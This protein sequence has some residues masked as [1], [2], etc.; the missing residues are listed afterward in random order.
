[1]YRNAIVKVPASIWLW[2]WRVSGF[3]V[4]SS[5][6][7]Q[8]PGAEFCSQS[9]TYWIWFSKGVEKRA[10]SC[11]SQYQIAV[12]F[13]YSQFLSFLFHQLLGKFCLDLY[14]LTPLHEMILALF[15]IVRVQAEMQTISQNIIVCLSERLWVSWSW[16]WHSSIHP[17]RVYMVVRSCEAWQ[18]R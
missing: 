17:H 13:C 8:W 11:P 18:T 9:F 7:L 16:S 10:F 3:Q 1:M 4:Q 12:W 6:G 15:P 14:C 5:L 2:F